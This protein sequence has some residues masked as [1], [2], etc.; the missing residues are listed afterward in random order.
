MA[1]QHAALQFGTELEHSYT[2]SAMDVGTAC[3]EG[4]D[5][6]SAMDVGT[7]CEEGQDT[8]LAMDVGAACEAEGQKSRSAMDVGAACEEGQ[9]SRSAMDVGTAFDDFKAV[10]ECFEKLKKEHHHPLRVFNSQSAQDYN[11]KRVNAKN[12]KPPVDCQKI[13]YTYYSV[14]CVHYGEPRSSRGSGIRPNQRSFS[15]GCQ[16]KVTL[17][18]DR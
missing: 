16:A 11:R 18:Y 15:K 1:W 6:R 4:L 7:A 14:R 17:S 12:P 3:E 10:E 8:R 13:R 9:K 5:T 2:R